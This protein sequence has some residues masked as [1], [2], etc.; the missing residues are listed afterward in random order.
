LSIFV[1]HRSTRRAEQIVS[2]IRTSVGKSGDYAAAI[3]S[4]N[5]SIADGG[6]WSVTR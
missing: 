1:P 6:K 4:V 3:G 5:V 2:G